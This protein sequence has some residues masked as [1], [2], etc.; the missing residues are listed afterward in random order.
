MTPQKLADFTV[1]Y[2]DIDT[3]DVMYIASCTM[4]EFINKYGDVN[5][6]DAPEASLSLYDMQCN[7][8]RYARDWDGH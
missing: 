5:G 3:N 4:S 2:L 8:K 6:K 1:Y 7:L